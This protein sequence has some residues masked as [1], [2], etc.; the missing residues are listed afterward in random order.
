MA[1]RYDI[2]Q[3]PVLSLM[4]AFGG[5]PVH[6]RPAAYTEAALAVQGDG[7]DCLQASGAL[8]DA[9]NRGNLLI[10][11]ASCLRRVKCLQLH[12]GVLSRAL[13]MHAS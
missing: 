4:V 5:L 6:I 13:A 7:S 1:P 9:L 3:A 12:P 2:S 11:G 8:W 10:C